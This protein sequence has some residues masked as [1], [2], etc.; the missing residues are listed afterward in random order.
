VPAAIVAYSR[1][2]TG[3]HWPSDVLV[4]I[5]L[6]IGFALLSVSFQSWLYQRFAR[7]YF[8]T[9]AARFPELVPSASSAK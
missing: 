6:A 4:S 8:P 2:Y 9:L 7:R 5:V 1:I 3:S